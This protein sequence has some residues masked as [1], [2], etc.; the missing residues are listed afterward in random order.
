MAISMLESDWLAPHQLILNAKFS[1]ITL[2]LSRSTYHKSAKGSS[3]PCPQT[4]W[5]PRVNE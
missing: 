5:A 4:L 3:L 1:L 2:L